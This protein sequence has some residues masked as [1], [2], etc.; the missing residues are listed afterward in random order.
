MI[1][2]ILKKNNITEV[3]NKLKK[4]NYERSKFFNIVY[5]TASSREL[6]LAISFIISVTLKDNIEKHL[7]KS[8][9]SESYD[10]FKENP[11][12]IPVEP[13]KLNEKDLKNYKK[14]ISGKICLNNNM[15][16]EYNEQVK[17]IYEKVII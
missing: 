16:S 11:D 10:D 2:K 8:V 17:K 1:F 13:P 3:N 4:L 12:T 5:E 14:W 7:N 15:I 9:F 6:L